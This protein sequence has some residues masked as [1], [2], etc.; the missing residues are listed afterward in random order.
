[1]VLEV[2]KYILLV[3]GIIAVGA[4]IVYGLANLMLAIVDPHGKKS[5]NNE[6]KQQER[7][8]VY[9]QA[10][11]IEQAPATEEKIEQK[12]VQDV[13]L[14][15][16]REEELA[17]SQG[18]AF[19]TLNDEEDAFIKEK[20]RNI[21]ERLAAKNAK[22][23]AVDEINLDDIFV[24]PTE[25][26]V[27]EPVAT[28]VDDDDDEDIDAL[29][30][31]ILSESD[32]EDEEEQ[33]VEEP[34][35][36]MDDEV[37]EASEELVEAVE[38]AVAEN[39]VAEEAHVVEETEEVAEET[40]ANAEET[41]AN[42]EPVIDEKEERLKA[43]EEELARQKEEYEA[44]LQEAL[45]NAKDEEQEEQANARIAELEKE[46]AEKDA[47]L[48]ESESKQ[49]GATL[50]L[51]EYEA[52]LE[53]LKDRLKVNDKELRAVKKE[54]L[55]LAKIKKSWEKDRVKLRRKEALVAKQKVVLYGVNNY[56]DI[57]EEKAKKLAEDLDLLDGLRLSVQ[58]C[59]EV[60]KANE[61]RFPIL[62]NSYNI[63][64]ATNENIK[65]DIE[66]CNA[67]IAELK[68]NQE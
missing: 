8:I 34:V 63:L 22:E 12:D 25:D 30:N 40:V 47:L 43:L 14:Q 27:E 39:E 32:D 65:A 53:T 38:E 58:H 45:A 50:S 2:L 19:A 16:A 21:E 24:D 4:L 44:K 64:L 41:T 18:N 59:E 57:D 31:R 35:A 36:T 17:L 66:E 11:L 67:R 46:L 52:R 29:I 68:A 48:A 56:V 49:T 55:P 37:E 23:E 5:N 60:M 6:E 54:Y 33:P 1:M 20:Q 28:E 42:E 9:E 26:E 3:V 10:K 7:Q 61:E 15:K 13:D 51:E 62:E